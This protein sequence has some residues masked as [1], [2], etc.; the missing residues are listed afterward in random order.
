[1]PVTQGDRACAFEESQP[2]K[3][4]G[5]FLCAGLYIRFLMERANTEKRNWCVGFIATLHMQ[6]M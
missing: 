2:E 1:M 6:S 5:P 3:P 4:Y